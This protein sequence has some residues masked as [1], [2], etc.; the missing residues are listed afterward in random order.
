MLRIVRRGNAYS[1]DA[2]YSVAF[3]LRPEA[4]SVNVYAAPNILRVVNFQSGNHLNS[5]KSPLGQRQEVN[6]ML[7]SAD[8]IA[9]E[10]RIRSADSLA[11]LQDFHDPCRLCIFAG[12]GVS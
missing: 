3:Q 2:F 4:N 12:S 9:Q 6:R 7:E 5:V 1:D 8:E 11:T 10:A